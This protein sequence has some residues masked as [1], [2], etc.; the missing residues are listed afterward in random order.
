MNR[1]IDL[2]ATSTEGDCLTVANYNCVTP[3]GLCGH[4]RYCRAIIVSPLRGFRASSFD[5]GYNCVTPTGRGA[6]GHLHLIRAIIV[7]PLRGGGLPAFHP[8]KRNDRVIL[9]V[10]PYAGS[11]P[12]KNKIHE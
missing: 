12:A 6:S 4:L 3:S 11:S 9:P 8:T 7:S 1:Y 2:T 10:P 5:P